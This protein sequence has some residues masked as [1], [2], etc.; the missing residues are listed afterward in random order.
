MQNKYVGDIGDFGKYGLLRYILKNTKV[1]LGINWCYVKDETNNNDGKHI[2]YLLNENNNYEI[3]RKCDEPL[4]DEL[5][6]I[7]KPKRE[8]DKVI[9]ESDI[10]NLDEIKSRLFKDTPCFKELMNNRANWFMYSLEQLTNCDIIFLDPDNGLEVKSYPKTSKRHVKY[11]Y[12]DEVEQYL[13]DGKSVIIYQHHDRKTDKLLEVRKKIKP[14]Y[15]IFALNFHRY[16]L[17]Y[18]VFIFQKSHHKFKNIVK[19]Q[20]FESPWVNKHVGSKKPH[21]TANLIS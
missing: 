19:K 16:D 18:F 10:R 8:G 17:R 11:L 12:Y 9:S 5:F 6:E 14:Q 3:Y 15:E 1:K 4:Y 7:V 2:A 20:F 13:Q 21:F